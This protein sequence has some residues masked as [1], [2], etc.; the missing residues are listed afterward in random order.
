MPPPQLLGAGL[1]E[2]LDREVANR[3]EHREAAVAAS[4]Q[5]VVDEHAEALERDVTDALGG[6]Q[7]A[8]AGEDAEPLEGD[9]LV[10]AEQVVAP[11]D[12]GGQRA[13]ACRRAAWAGREHVRRALQ[14]PEGRC[15]PEHVR[16]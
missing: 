2:S 13:L 10:R 4:Q 8:A 11:L 12:R 9:A 7:G 14:T 5:V 15:P 6:L 1:L 3:L 16:A